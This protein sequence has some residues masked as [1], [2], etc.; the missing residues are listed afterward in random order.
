MVVGIYLVFS[1]LLGLYLSRRGTRSL[2][3]FFVSG[4]SL[5]WW[6]AGTSM[7]ATTFSIDTPLYVCGLVAQRGVAGNWEWWS[8]GLTHVVMIYIFAR[9]WRRSEIITDAELTELRYGGKPAA[10]LRA[11][12]AFLFAVPIN[13]IGMGYALLATVKVIDALDIWN[14][15]G[16]D[17]G[18]NG[19]LWS[20][21]GVSVLVLI[22]AGVAGLWGVVVTDLF[23]F[24]LALGGAVLVAGVALH[25][26]GGMGTVVAHFQGTEMLRLWPW[27]EQVGLSASTLF[28]YMFVQWWAFR[29]SDGG[30]EFIQRLAAAKDEAEAE[31]AAWWFNILNY[32]VRTWPWVVVALV[33]RVIYPDLSDPELG[34]PRLMR[35]FLPPVLLGLVVASLLAAFMSTMSTLINWGASYLTRDLY[36]RFWRP[37][38]SQTELVTAGRLASV[39][40]TALGAVAA[41]Y[42]QDVTAVFRLVI[43]IGTGPGVVLILRWFWWRVNAVA[44]WTAMVA[45][46]AIGLGT[47]VVP[48][49]QIPDF[50]WRLMV[51]TGITA[52]A[53]LIAMYSTAPESE[54]T[55]NEFYRRIRPGG[56]GWRRQKQATGLAP[57]QD[58]G[59]ELQRTL[60]GIG[61]LFGSMLGVG[62]FLLW[63][64]LVGW[65][66]WILAVGA[67]WWLAKLQ[68][69]VN[70]G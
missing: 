69:R 37:Q 20:V 31:R 8:F 47:T 54:A 53:W 68:R 33:A 41:F 45:G 51:T 40:V 7:A 27:G 23:Q 52:L 57:L 12:K 17:P 43:A 29:R 21:V 35:D 4:R 60:A 49:I 16:I 14:S 10:I 11:T 3:D 25:H 55:L 44:E 58:L 66:A 24:V 18:V 48:V 62:G 30:G 34:Y 26:V 22:Y 50:G 38:A 1:L 39:G 61:L 32:V 9:L 64:P 5:P 19:K 63:Q 36:Q 15:L 56:P 2:V 70:P 28:G 65:G 13:C 67:G 46:F 6:L 59:W 42:A